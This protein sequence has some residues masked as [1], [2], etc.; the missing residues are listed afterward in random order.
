MHT[1]PALHLPWRVLVG[2]VGTVV[3]L[4]GIV[5]LVTPGPGVAA[6]LMG[7]LILSTEFRWAY[8]LLQPARTWAWRAEQYAERRKEEFLRRRR[9]R[10]AAKDRPASTRKNGPGPD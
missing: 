4:A 3:A 9:E 1:H 5:F 8:R 7:L 6:V 2:T 10:K